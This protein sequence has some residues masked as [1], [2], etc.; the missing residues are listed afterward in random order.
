MPAQSVE[1]IYDRVE[2]F[3]ILLAAAELHAS[4]AWELQF[5]EDIRAGY[6]RHGPS[7][8]LSIAQRETLERIAKY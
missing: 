2:E 5:T 3:S 7:T 1:E 4:G 6:K 8:H